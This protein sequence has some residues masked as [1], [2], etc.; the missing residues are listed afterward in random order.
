ML[1]KGGEETDRV[2]ALEGAPEHAGVG[3]GDAE[4]F[5][6]EGAEVGCV[7]FFCVFL[8]GRGVGAGHGW[9]GI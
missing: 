8:V 7:G 2:G 3:G 1:G 4:V 5:V 6:E 9:D